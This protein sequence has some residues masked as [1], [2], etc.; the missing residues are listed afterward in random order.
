MSD[1]RNRT[2]IE[3]RIRHSLHHVADTVTEGNV[4]TVRRDDDKGKARRKWRIVLAAGALTLIPAGFASAALVNTP[5]DEY[6]NA[7]PR[8]QIV[9]EGT[10]DGSRYLLIESHRTGECGEPVTGVELFEESENPVGSEWSTTGY[11]YGEYVDK[12]CGYVNDPSRYLANPALF[13][14]SGAEVG[15]SFVWVYAV[16]PDVD[17]VRIT[18][19]DYST[20]L[21]VYEVDGAGY[22]PFEVPKGLVQYTSELLIDGHVVPGSEATRTVP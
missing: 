18:A 2:D 16:H 20:K 14:D 10:V 5:D 12:S 19:E 6:V 9:M 21:K 15:D 17:A 1:I 13:N 8:S 7:V 11:E 3:R 22:A 4:A